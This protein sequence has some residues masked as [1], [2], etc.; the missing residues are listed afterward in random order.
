MHIDLLQ[1]LGY[2]SRVF[3]F[4]N[5]AQLLVQVTAMAAALKKAEDDKQVLLRWLDGHAACV[6]AATLLI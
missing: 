6:Y 3:L 1:H 2:Q 5:C 4:A